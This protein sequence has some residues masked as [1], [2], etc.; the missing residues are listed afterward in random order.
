MMMSII[1][2]LSSHNLSFFWILYVV[3]FHRMRDPF[4]IEKAAG[5]SNTG[6][7][8]SYSMFEQIVRHSAD[9]DICSKISSIYWRYCLKC[10]FLDF[11]SLFPFSW[12]NIHTIDDGWDISFVYLQK[13]GILPPYFLKPIQSRIRNIGTEGINVNKASILS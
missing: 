7:T 9:F 8:L 6:Y 3:R 12:Q 1:A 11:L 2:R 4:A 13:K 10:S 5:F